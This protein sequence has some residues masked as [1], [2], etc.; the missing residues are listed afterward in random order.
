MRSG[1]YFCE[2]FRVVR[3]LP[4]KVV[5][6]QLDCVNHVFWP[7]PTPLNKIVMLK[8]D[9]HRITYCNLVGIFCQKCLP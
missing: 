2:I 8:I 9:L 6:L 1:S 4:E 3:T 5:A 7:S